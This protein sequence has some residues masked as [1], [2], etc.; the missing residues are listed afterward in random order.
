MLMLRRYVVVLLAILAA[1]SLAPVPALAG[2]GAGG[3][4]C[5]NPSAP[6]CDVNAGTP[7]Q[8]GNNTG[9]QNGGSGGDQG[10]SSDTHCVYE[11]AYPSAETIAGLGGQ[12]AGEG[13]W[14]FKSCYQDDG[15]EVTY[16]GPSWIADAP[17][18]VSPAV[19]AQQARSRLRLPSVAIRLNPSGDQLV[20]LPTWLALDGN[21]WQSRSA[22]ASVPGISVTAT[23]R[24]VRAVWSLG[25]GGLVTCTGSGTPWTA[26]TDP[27]AASPDCGY[28]YRRSSAGAAGA[29]FSVTVTVTW[30]VTWAGAGRSG[31]I[32]GL[33]TT[34]TVPVRVTE[35][36]A[37]ITS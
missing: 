20:N 35:S 3:T 11:P 37:V 21:S 17:P 15:I 2:D 13:G 7:G 34:G 19:L 8:P 31:T 14:Y 10:G 30:E 27:M 26:G 16:P 18:V 9:G 23:A 25:E 1:T 33:N 28:T 24:P 5:S 4:T 12:P 29:A 22:T 36:Q 32:A 6:E